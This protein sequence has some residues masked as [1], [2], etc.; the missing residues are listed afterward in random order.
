MKDCVEHNNDNKQ[1]L[2]SGVVIVGEDQ[3]FK[4]KLLD[5]IVQVKCRGEPVSDLYGCVSGG[6]I[7]SDAGDCVNKQCKCNSG[8]TGDFCE[9]LDN[10]SSS[11]DLA[12]ILGTIVYSVSALITVL[13]V[14]R[15]AVFFFRCDHSSGRRRVASTAMLWIDRCIHYPS[16]EETKR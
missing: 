15:T 13:V 2:R 16:Q 8:R 9:Q 3:V 14:L 4:K 6:V 1:F 11:S 10:N 5:L 12:I 7:C